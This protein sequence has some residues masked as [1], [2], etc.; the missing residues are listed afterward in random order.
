MLMYR[1]QN[2]GLFAVLLLTLGLGIVR[3]QMT[4]PTSTPQFTSPTT[5]EI[6]P[7][8]ATPL[9]I[10]DA[11]RFA[12]RY[13]P[14]TLRA[15]D[16]VLIALAQVRSAA[17]G[18]QPSVGITANASWLPNP[19]APFVI[20]GSNGSK[21][22]SITTTP[23]LSSAGQLTISQPIWPS[24]RW[25]API[26][27][28]Q[29]NVGVTQET[30]RRTLQ[31]TAFITRQAFYQL[32]TAQEMVQVAKDAVDVATTQVGLAQKNLD[33]GIAAKIDVVQAQAN[34]ADAQ[35]NLVR[36]QNNQ[37]IARATLDVQLGLPAGT[38][39]AIVAPNPNDLPN[40]PEN[41]DAM[42]TRALQ[43]R[44]ELQ[45]IN[46]RRQQAHANIDLIR[47]Q[48]SPIVSMQAAYNKTFVGGSLFGSDGWTI[49][50]AGSIN[51]YNGGKMRADLDAAR[52]QLQQ[53]D[54]VARQ[55]ELGITFDIRQAWVN[56]VTALEQ[57]R[58]A[59]H[60]YDAADEALRIARIRYENGMGI[61]LEVDQAQ[62]RRNTAQTALAQARLQAKVA[63]AQMDYAVGAPVPGEQPVPGATA[64][65][66]TMSLSVPTH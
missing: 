62:L 6:P 49:S 32:A 34:Q 56:L 36:A 63:V 11:V 4:L 40:A 21:G 26:A 10:D 52:L 23:A 39:V 1:N 35:V 8:P 2:R 20:P 51:L 28:A 53:L 43:L 29:A 61:Q 15:E 3:A 37:D 47:L 27:A 59:Q 50:A 66:P 7:V 46:F 31:Q 57:Y 24:N 65:K 60:Q 48:Q 12:L 55:T 5:L 45:Q 14:G 44:P 64:P 13:N 19:P 58:D 38:N 16:D 30:Y 33:A 22:T 54:A 41:Q 18:R 9:S 25:R 42:V 17:S